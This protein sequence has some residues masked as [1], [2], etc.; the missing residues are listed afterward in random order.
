MDIV[1]RKILIPALCL[2]LLC[3]ALAGCR[4][5]EAAEAERLIAA[6]SADAPDADAVARAREAYEA[7]PEEEQEALEN[8]A[9]LEQAESRLR[10]NAANE[11]IAALGEITLESA[12]AILAARESCGALTPYERTLVEDLPALAAAEEELHRLEVEAAAAEIDALIEAVG[13]VGTESRAALEAA[14][15]AYDAADEEVRAAVRLGGTLTEAEKKLRALEAQAAASG[16]DASVEA[17]GEVT[18]DREA[19]VT[20]LRREYDAFPED[21]R[22]LVTQGDAL[23]EAERAITELKDR[24]V[25]DEVKLLC[26]EKK[27]DEAITRAETQIGTRPPAEVGGG[28]V[29]S[30]LKAYAAKGNA[31]LKEQRYEDAYMLL[32]SC[33]ETYAGQDLAEVDK[34]W[35]ALKTAI[36]EPK[37]GQF[38]NAAARGGY[39]TLTVETGHSPAFIKV[40]SINDPKRVLS[41]YVRADSKT[42]VHVRNGTYTLRYATGERWFGTKQMFGSGTVYR[43]FDDNLGFSAKYG[44]SAAGREV[45]C[46]A[47]KVTLY[48]VAGGTAGT[49]PI[50]ADEF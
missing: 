44:Y 14:R 39:G 18:L 49:T 9:L 2:V 20:A 29:K 7:L 8:A 31:L 41:F 4:S 40:I 27:Y 46:S 25:S 17:L 43:A 16:F 38:F 45:R 12:D 32:S 1:R 47:W 28:L 11:S 10:V 26:D 50:N 3:G 42:T 30:C 24:E 37:N 22:A 6:L 36:A 15:T 21:V 33:R 34:A 35:N 48:P 23:S 19:D 13:E 5:S